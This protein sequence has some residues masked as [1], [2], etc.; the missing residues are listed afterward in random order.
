MMRGDGVLDGVS[1]SCQYIS[2]RVIVDGAE[3][4]RKVNKIALWVQVACTA[5][6]LAALHSQTI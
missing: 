6:A 4:P 2:K 5:T 3:A 1:I